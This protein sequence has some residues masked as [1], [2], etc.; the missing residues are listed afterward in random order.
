[1]IALLKLFSKDALTREVHKAIIS[2]SYVDSRAHMLACFA[3]G[4]D[5][6][7]QTY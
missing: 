1:M 5:L 4:D 2:D 3:Q 7:K 6:N